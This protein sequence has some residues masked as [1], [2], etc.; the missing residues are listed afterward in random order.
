MRIVAQRVKNA[1]VTVDGTITG[2]INHG[3]LLFVGF[4]EGD[5]Q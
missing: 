3:L 5:N 2:K 1:S 4:T